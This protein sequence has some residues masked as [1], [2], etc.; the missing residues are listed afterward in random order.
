VRCDLLNSE[1]L[2]VIF[3]HPEEWK[4]A[5]IMAVFKRKT[6]G[7]RRWLF[8]IIKRGYQWIHQESLLFTTCIK[9]ILYDLTVGYCDIII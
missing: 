6:E 7:R 1:L 8:F 4:M 5:S 2:S 9:G 3:I